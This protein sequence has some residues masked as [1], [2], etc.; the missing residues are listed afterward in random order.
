MLSQCYENDDGDNPT[1]NNSKT[2]AT[3]RLQGL[4]TKVSLL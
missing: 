1:S 3:D 4:R 2:L